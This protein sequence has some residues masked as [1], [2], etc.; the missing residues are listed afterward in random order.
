VSGYD[1][2]TTRAQARIGVGPLMPGARL[3]VL[4]PESGRALGVGEEGELA[5]GGA[6]LMLG[7]LGGPPGA[8]LDADGFFHTGDAG[9]V[10]ADG[11]VHFSGRRTEMIKTGGANVSPAELE[12]ALRACPSV[13]LSRI[14]GVP[15]ERLGQVVV[16][17]IVPAES[18]APTEDV[19]RSFLRDRVA[20]YKVPRHVLFLTED[21]MP[22]T[23]SDTK[24]RDDAL[25]ALVA[26]RLDGVTTVPD[27]T[28][29]GER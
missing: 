9:H 3:R 7:Y 8:G 28:P 5:V 21:E 27:P 2:R 1:C 6:T 18:S 24:V 14:V 11:I 26:D 29:T 16:A 13:K 25:R 15:D 4:D 10:D 17:C 19:I 23:D 20:P 12:V 22:M